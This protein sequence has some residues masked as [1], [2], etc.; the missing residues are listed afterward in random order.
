MIIL[1]AISASFW[2]IPRFVW[3]SH[4]ANIEVISINA[5]FLAS[6][7][8][9]WIVFNATGNKNITRRDSTKFYQIYS[10]NFK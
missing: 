7:S 1:S 3:T 2:I 8:I 5:L 10:S 4:E 6:D 9:A